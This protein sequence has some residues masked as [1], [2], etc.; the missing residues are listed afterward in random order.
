[1]PNIAHERICRCA[2]HKLFSI[3]PLRLFFGSEK[4]EQE[5]FDMFVDLELT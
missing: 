4:I 2:I 5:T 3:M 1:M